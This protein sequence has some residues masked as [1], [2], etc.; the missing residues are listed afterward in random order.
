LNFLKAQT[1]YKDK[2]SPDFLI[3]NYLITLVILTLDRIIA[4]YD[5][6]LEHEI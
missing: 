6:S 4:N 5:E 3:G 1:S 2:T